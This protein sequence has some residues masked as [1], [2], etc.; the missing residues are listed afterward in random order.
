MP[1]IACMKSSWLTA[2][3]I[4]WRIFLSLKGAC[5]WLKRRMPVSGSGSIA[6]IETLRLRRSSCWIS[7]GGCSYQSISPV[8]MAAAAVAASTMMCH[9]TRSKCATLGPAVRL[10]VPE[11]TGM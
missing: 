5:R 1:T 10:G 6:S 9:S 3:R 4:A 2:G 7:G 8:W 11:E